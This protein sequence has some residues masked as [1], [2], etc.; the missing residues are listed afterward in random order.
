MQEYIEAAARKQRYCVFCGYDMSRM[1]FS[2]IDGHHVDPSLKSFLLSKHS[3][4]GMKAVIAEVAK[5]VFG[6]SGCHHVFERHEFI[7]RK[8]SDGK[9]VFTTQDGRKI[10]FVG[11][12]EWVVDDGTDVRE[13]EGQARRVPEGFRQTD[14]LEF[15]CDSG[16]PG[17]PRLVEVT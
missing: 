17:D 14:L 13:A 15:V 16:V 7:M 8:E 9:F 3:E 2:G 5:C 12:S 4:H 6:C 10:R 1:D 11:P